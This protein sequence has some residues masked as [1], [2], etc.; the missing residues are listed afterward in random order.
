MTATTASLKAL[1]P[2]THGELAP[3]EGVHLSRQITRSEHIMPQT[4]DDE[5]GWKES[6][7]EN[8]EDVHDRL[9]NNLGNLTLTGYNQEYSNRSF[10]DKLN[11]PGV[12]L[13]VQSAPPE[14]VNRL[15]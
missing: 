13:K 2:G 8:W 4:I 9:C 7:G 11:L 12:G 6:L 3:P 15:A 1:L 5:H 10:S 14:Q